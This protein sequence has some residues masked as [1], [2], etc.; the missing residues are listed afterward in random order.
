MKYFIH[1]NKS[2]YVEAYG[3][4]KV[5]EDAF[6]FEIPEDILEDFQINF[7]SYK[8]SNNDTMVKDTQTLEQRE[9]IAYR[10]NR[11]NELKA[12]LAASDWKVVVNSELFQVGLPL[13][14]PNLHAERQAWRDEI[15]ELEGE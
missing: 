14:Y 11:T 5:T 2:G 13:K 8:F 4:D 15:N 10:F 6:E 12:L 3:P 1:L 9:A 7:P